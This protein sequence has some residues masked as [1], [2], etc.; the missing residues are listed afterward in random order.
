MCVWSKKLRYIQLYEADFN[1]F[2]QFI[3][4]TKAMNSL[5]G[6]SFLPEEYVSKK[7]STAEDAKLDNTLLEDLL[8]QV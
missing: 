2:Q 3:F 7:A 1:F 4:G 5:T 6:N 8:R